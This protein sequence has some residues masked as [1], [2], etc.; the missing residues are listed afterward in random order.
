M[1]ILKLKNKKKK[2]NFK[3]KKG[4]NIIEIQ[5]KNEGFSPPNTSRIELVD[6]KIKYPVITQLELGKSAIIKIY[7]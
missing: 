5:A 3:L 1:K 4:E 6:N 7:K 2:I